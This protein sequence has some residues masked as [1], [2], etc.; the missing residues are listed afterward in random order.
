MKRKTK[1]RR[2]KAYALLWEGRLTNPSHE[3]SIYRTQS[4]AE[5]VSLPSEKIVPVIIE[6]IRP[7][8]RRK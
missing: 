4:D 3:L 8:S 7:C 1:P 2:W 6:E 5:R